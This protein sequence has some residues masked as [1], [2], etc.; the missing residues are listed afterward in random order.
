MM[1]FAQLIDSH[2]NVDLVNTI[3]VTNNAYYV[4]LYTS[5]RLNDIEKFCCNGRNLLSLVVDTT[6]NLCEL[7][8]T[9]TSYKDKRTLSEAFLARLC[10][11][12][13]KM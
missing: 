13:Q 4:S 6:F 5:R 11:I 9:D 3:S 12:L 1:S 7:W 2:K 8:L 10:F